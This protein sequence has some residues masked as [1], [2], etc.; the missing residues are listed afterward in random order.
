MSGF[1]T[2]MFF[3]VDRQVHVVVVIGKRLLD[4]V[5]DVGQLVRL[6]LQV[7]V[8]VEIHDHGGRK[9]LVEA[10]DVAQFLD[11]AVLAGHDFETRL[12]EDVRMSKGGGR[13]QRKKRGDQYLRISHL[14]RCPVRCP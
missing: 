5:A 7:G 6:Q 8:L 3:P 2:V 10:P 9:D 4:R 13:R 11:T 12:H 1:W 14:S